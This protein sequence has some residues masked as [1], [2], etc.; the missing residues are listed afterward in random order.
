MHPSGTISLSFET[1]TPFIYNPPPCLA[2]TFRM[3]LC[4]YDA[5]TMHSL[6]EM[7][8]CTSLWGPFCGSD[9]GAH[10]SGKDCR[11]HARQVKI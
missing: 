1:E 3:V 9:F 11:R 4:G 10:E 7:Y 6:A 5:V 2:R 8:F